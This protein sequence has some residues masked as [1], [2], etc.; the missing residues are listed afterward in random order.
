M[1]ANPF[2]CHTTS[3]SAR[4]LL[5]LPALDAGD[6]RLNKATLYSWLCF[7]ARAISRGL[8]LAD[9]DQF[10]RAVELA[11]LRIRRNPSRSE[12]LA[13]DDQLDLDLLLA[14]LN[15]RATARVND[16]ASVVLRDVVLWLLYTVEH[17]DVR[18][19]S[20][21]A[22]AVRVADMAHEPESALLDAATELVV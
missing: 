15:D 19:A 7:I 13:D 14:I 1:I 9:L 3:S 10:L 11:R 17:R 6:I 21:L 16:V 20:A 8:Q 12:R 22:H 4:R 18:W 5:E 2:T